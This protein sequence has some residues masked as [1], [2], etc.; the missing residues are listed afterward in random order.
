VQI[1]EFQIK[2]FPLVP[3]YFVLLRTKYPP[4]HP[5]LEHLILRSYLNV[6]DQVS[7]PYA[8]GKIIHSSL[9]FIYFFWFLKP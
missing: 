6:S 4:P 3:Y 7:H 2:Q 5:I 8:A 9:Y 1:I